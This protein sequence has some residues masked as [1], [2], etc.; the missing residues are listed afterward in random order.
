MLIA[1]NVAV[2]VMNKKDADQPASKPRNR[3]MDN[4]SFKGHREAQFL[5]QLTKLFWGTDAKGNEQRL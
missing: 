3:W 4:R 5:K 2:M 1:K